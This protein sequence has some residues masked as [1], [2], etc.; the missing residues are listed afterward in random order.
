MAARR[1]QAWKICDVKLIDR[2]IE[3]GQVRKHHASLFPHK[4]LAA[5]QQQVNRR[6]KLAGVSYP[7]GRP[8]LEA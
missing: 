6:K 3:E 1:D 4:S 8:R 7:V 5:F 2:L